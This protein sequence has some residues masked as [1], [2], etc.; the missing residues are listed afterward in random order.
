[1]HWQPITLKQFSFQHDNEGGEWGWVQAEDRPLD[2]DGFGGAGVHWS[3]YS[4][5]LQAS[6]FFLELEGV[7]RN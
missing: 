6:I 7:K 2:S 1:M 5:A 4:K 3:V